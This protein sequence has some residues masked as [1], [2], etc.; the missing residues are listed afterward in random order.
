MGEKGEE[1]FGKINF[2]HAK[3]L[4]EIHTLLGNNQSGFL[5]YFAGYMCVCYPLPP[6]R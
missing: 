3:S 5:A 1:K 4:K 2:R 6:I